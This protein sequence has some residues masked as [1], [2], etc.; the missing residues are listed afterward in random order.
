MQNLDW[1]WAMCNFSPTDAFGELEHLF[2]A[3]L[4][5]L[6]TNPFDAQQWEEAYG[7][8]AALGIRFVPIGSAQPIGTDF[9]LHIEG[10]KAG[11]VTE[12]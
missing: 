1:P 10:D 11:F 12:T 4:T 9:L 3:E 6:N 7:K 8:V 5:I 2:A